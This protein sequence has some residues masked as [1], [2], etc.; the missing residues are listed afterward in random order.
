M[1]TG[2]PTAPCTTPYGDFFLSLSIQNKQDWARLHNVELQLMAES[3][4]P[5][6]RPGA[7]QKIALIRQV[8]SPPTP[9]RHKSR[10]VKLLHC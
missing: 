1:L 3:F 6:L 8:E 4:D 2:I 5:K 9:P 7:W 10:L